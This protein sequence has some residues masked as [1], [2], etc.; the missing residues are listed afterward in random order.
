M[1]QIEVVKDS[2][3]YKKVRRHICLPSLGV[4]LGGFK[5]CQCQYIIIFQRWQLLEPYSSTPVGDTHIQPLTVLY[6]IESLTTF[7]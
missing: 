2:V 3:W 4:E 5:D 6:Q 1:L 7:I